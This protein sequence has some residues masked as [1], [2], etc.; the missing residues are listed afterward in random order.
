MSCGERK[1]VPV[2]IIQVLEVDENALCGFWAHVA[3][4]KKSIRISRA[5]SRKG[6][7]KGKGKGKG[8]DVLER[9]HIVLLP[10]DQA[11]RAN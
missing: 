9:K 10:R 7:G 1:F 6:N 2:V 4:D 5:E 11:R 8:K 3:M